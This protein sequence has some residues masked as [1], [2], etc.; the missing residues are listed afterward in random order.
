M[1][2]FGFFHA[3]PMEEEDEDE[4]NVK[5]SMSKNIEV[6]PLSKLSNV[7]VKEFAMQLSNTCKTHMSWLSDSNK[8]IEFKF[9]LNVNPSQK[10]KN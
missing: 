3:K 10:L 7:N 5:Q 2:Y 1:K 8:I 4:E 6:S 9:C